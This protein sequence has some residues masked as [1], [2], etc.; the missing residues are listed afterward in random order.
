[1]KPHPCFLVTAARILCQH[2]VLNTIPH[3]S[4]QTIVTQGDKIEEFFVVLVGSMDV[5]LRD[6]ETGSN[7]TIGQLEQGQ[8]CAHRCHARAG[9][10]SI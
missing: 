9:R 2:F 1:M 3:A 4:G 7:F 6:E 8:V 5:I 10:H